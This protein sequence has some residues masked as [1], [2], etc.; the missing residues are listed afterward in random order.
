MMLFRCIYLEACVKEI[1]RPVMDSDPT[2]TKLRKTINIHHKTLG[3][4]QNLRKRNGSLKS[5]RTP[6]Y[7]MVHTVVQ[8]ATPQL[9]R[10]YIGYIRR[11]LN[12]MLNTT[13]QLLRRCMSNKRLH[14][15]YD[16]LQHLY[17]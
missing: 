12:P 6:C 10:S 3:E 13:K 4:I 7:E 8:G 16:L 9:G 2:S 17:L 5:G 15:L 1:K 11:L 14:V